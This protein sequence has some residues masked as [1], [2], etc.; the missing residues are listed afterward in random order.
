VSLP[1]PLEKAVQ[2]QI[3]T[4]FRHA[5]GVVRSNSQYRASGVSLGFPDLH[6]SFPRIGK[7]TWFEVKRPK[8]AGFDFG[9]P[10]TWQPE[11]LRPDQEKFRDDCLAT[12]QP[13]SW[14][15]LREA[16]AV[17]VAFGLAAMLNGVFTLTVRRAA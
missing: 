4:L 10:Q 17:L 11:G 8:L 9:K 7:W 3:V 16:E 1:R 12:G 5:G 14:G 13:H 15:G 6:V 2:A